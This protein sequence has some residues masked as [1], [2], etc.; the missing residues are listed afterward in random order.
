[1]IIP[2]SGVMLQC[3]SK[4]RVVLVHANIGAIGARK[5]DL[6]RPVSLLAEHRCGAAANLCSCIETM[7]R[8]APTYGL[9]HIACTATDSGRMQC[10]AVLSLCR[11]QQ[12]QTTIHPEQMHT[13]CCAEHC[14]DCEDASMAFL[15]HSP[16][17]CAEKNHTQQ[18]P[19][20]AL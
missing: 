19:A 9:L 13:A 14:K 5:H 6:Q 16:V 12:Q 8:D 7:Q 15:K 11:E 2:M 20:T 1:M 4:G 18:T 17:C 3:Y 10:A